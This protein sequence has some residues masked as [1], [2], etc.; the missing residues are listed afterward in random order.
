[1]LLRTTADL[2]GTGGTFRGATAEEVLAKQPAD[3]G[4]FWWVQVRKDGLSGKQAR[5]ALARSVQVSPELVGDAGN[6]DRDVVFTQW[7]SLPVDAVDHVGPL[8]R[9][10]A[11]GKLQVL[12]LTRSHKPIT[13]ETVGRIRWRLRIKG[14]NKNDGYQKA[15][16]IL[17]RLRVQGVPNF[18]DPERFGPEGNLARWGRMILAGERLPPTVA[19]N[20]EIG[21]SKRA[22][23]LWCFNHYLTQRTQD[24]LLGTCL[25]GDLMLSRAG[26]YL[27]AEDPVH[28]QKRMD[29]WEVIPQGPVFGAGLEESTG[30]AGEREATL[31]ASLGLETASFAGLP[32]ERRSIRVQPQQVLLDLDGEDLLVACDLPAEAY[33]AVLVAEIIG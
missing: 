2:P 22:A 3:T 5:E 17:D 15:K 8:R 16:A 20:V 28:M 14:G 24:G 25:A 27:L 31:L 19:R 30:V 18:V 29:S 9:A 13:P 23:Q 4:D 6:R 7:F 32:G 1:M 11:H 12:K 33:V 10:G 26:A 21:R